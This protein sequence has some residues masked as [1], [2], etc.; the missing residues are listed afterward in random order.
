[1]YTNDKDFR[2]R[3]RIYIIST[4]PYPKYIIDCISY[5]VRGEIIE[6]IDLIDKNKKYYHLGP[7]EQLDVEAIA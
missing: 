1:M 5:L 2:R 4:N 3:Y 7:G 6:W